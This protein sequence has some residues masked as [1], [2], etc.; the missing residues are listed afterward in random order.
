MSQL[1]RNWFSHYRQPM[2]RN[3][4]NFPGQTT[5]PGFTIPHFAAIERAVVMLSPV[6]ILTIIPARWHVKIASGTC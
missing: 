2:T 6:T 4:D 3:N 5:L 1:Q